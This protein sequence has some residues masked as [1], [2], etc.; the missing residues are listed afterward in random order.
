MNEGAVSHSWASFIR[1]L[2]ATMKLQFKR[3]LS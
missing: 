1:A 2:V 3:S